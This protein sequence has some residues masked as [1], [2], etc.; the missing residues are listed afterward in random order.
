MGPDN[1]LLRYDA[2]LKVLQIISAQRD[3]KSLVFKLS[4]QLHSVLEFTHFDLLLY[5]EELDQM[6]LFFP[7][8][9][10]FI[11]SHIRFSDG[12]G[13]WVWQN[14]KPY[15]AVST[16]L[17]R[18]FPSYAESRR[19]EQI[20]VFCVAPLTTLNRRLG[21]LHISSSV[22]DRPYDQSE[23]E[24]IQRMAAQIAIVLEST[25]NAEDA[26]A[27]ELELT[28]ERN[29]L[30]NLLEVSNAAVV[31]LEL[32]GML[33]EIAA[34]LKAIAG[35]ALVQIALEEESTH[36][37][38]WQNGD[39]LPA[40][41]LFSTGSLLPVSSFLVRG[42]Q[43][44][45]PQLQ[46]IDTEELMRLAIYSEE[47]AGIADRGLRELCTVPLVSRDRLLGV[48]LFAWSETGR[49]TPA[50][51]RK[52]AEIAGQLVASV[53][54]ARV[55]R[56]V[57]RLRDR[58]AEEKLYLEQELRL[59]HSFHEMIGESLALKHVLGQIEQVAES[60]STVLLLGETG[61]GKELVARAIHKLSLRTRNA[62]VKLN[63][64]AIPAGLLESELFGHERGAFTGAVTRK[65]GRM[66]L[67]DK[68]TLFLDEVGDMPLEL[69]PKLLRVL[70]EHEFER[71]GG[72]API[73]S[74]IRLIAATN[75][76]LI[77][78]VGEKSFRSDLF[79]R[80]NV[81]PI[82]L[83]PLRERRED[84]PLLVR[85]FTRRFALK[86]NR[87]IETIPS[88]TMEVLMQMD[89]PGNVRELENLVERAVI[90]SHGTV[91]AVPSADLASS[92]TPRPPAMR[93]TAPE[94]VA[95]QA[96]ERAFLLQILRE[97]GGRVAGPHGAAERLGIPRSTL[98][99]RLRLLGIEPRDV[100]TEARLQ[101]WQNSGRKTSES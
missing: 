63:C 55:Y 1:H 13:M 32:E 33:K 44:H 67:A 97:T 50:L 34:R 64:S 81:F 75:R 37:L 61:T 86:M 92:F 11:P 52:L 27:F 65:V 76:N 66:D 48:I 68:G 51:A 89:W 57:S 53:E 23:L 35:C 82:Q 85:H 87:R 98:F 94:A 16:E 72:H 71:V 80:L 29:H 60:D 4:E 40:Q 6:T 70:Q 25:A 18:Q 24:F 28:E 78:M 45:P 30:R 77:E 83:P 7:G 58:L 91:L 38:Y 9:P 99:S 59:E 3:L 2:L 69:Q 36:A 93:K 73:R 19:D 42:A 15:V 54:N 39:A 79:Y 46:V 43:L 90:V 100:R 101:Q 21:V 12:P 26:R 84:I 47:I 22:L 31:H 5:N 20:K 17:E 95:P 96:D 49:C 10:P 88:E 14:Q 8:V 74:D 62:L 41:Q 56:E